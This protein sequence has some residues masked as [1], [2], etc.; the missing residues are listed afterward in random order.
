MR[1]LDFSFRFAIGKISERERE[2][3]RWQEKFDLVYHYESFCVYQKSYDE[4][5]DDTTKEVNGEEPDLFFFQA[6]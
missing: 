5:Y 3:E 6:V 4:Y 1:E 2:M